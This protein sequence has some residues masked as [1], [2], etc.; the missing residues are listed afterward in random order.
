MATKFYFVNGHAGYDPPAFQGAWDVEATTAT[1]CLDPVK[2]AQAIG[3]PGHQEV[4][5]AETLTTNPTRVCV[6]RMISRRLAAQTI[7]GTVDLCASVRESSGNLNAFTR[8]HLYVQRVDDDSILG[9]LINQYEESSGGGGTEWPTG[10]TGRSLQSAQT[11]SDVTIPNDGN[12]YRLV[13]ELGVRAENTSATSM[14]GLVFVGARSSAN[15]ESSTDLVAGDAAL[16]SSRPGWIEF[17]GTVTL[18][19]DS[20]T[21]IRWEDAT[22]LGSNVDQT[23]AFDLRQGGA[24]YTRWWKYT[25][26]ADKVVSFF[27]WYDEGGGTLRPKGIIYNPDFSNMITPAGG[28]AASNATFTGVPVYSSVLSGETLYFAVQPNSFTDGPAAGDLTFES[29]AYGG[30]PTSGVYGMIPSDRGGPAAIID[31]GTGEVTVFGK[32]VST[33]GGDRLGNKLMLADP[34]DTGGFVIYDTDDMSVV[35]TNTTFFP[36]TNT[37]RTQHALNTFTVVAGTEMKQFSDVGA[38]VSTHTV[39]SFISTHA[40]DNAGAFLYHTTGVTNAPIKKWNLQTETAETD[41][42]AGI[43][44][45]VVYDLFVLSDGSILALYFQSSGTPRAIQVKRY[46]TGG[47]VLNTYSI[48]SQSGNP[49]AVTPRMFW[50]PAD[51]SNFWVWWH[52]S[53]GVT[54]FTKLDIATGSV[55]ASFDTPDFE[56]SSQTGGAYDGTPAADAPMWGATNSCPMVMF[57][58][59]P[60]LPVIDD[61]DPCCIDLSTLAQALGG[62][63]GGP[64]AGPGA[65]GPME[66][67]RTGTWSSSLNATG[68]GS[69]G[70]SGSSW[71][72]SD[73]TAEAW[74]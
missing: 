23:F 34:F 61:S 47:S 19:A 60:Q 74:G 72:S 37:I 64:I 56:G 53:S 24:N 29:K 17:S 68:G 43:A 35:T 7:S 46:D 15:Q 10:S 38:E 25:A 49:L 55:V 4:S 59:A 13:M 12:D 11:M 28:G 63:D 27:P 26:P 21:N 30:V 42:A 58:G 52:P 71:S 70:G 14:S 8:L 3:S 22:D 40:V 16:G 62:C 36:G 57:G 69:G 44:S 66:Q 41:L 39:P 5:R 18:H 67:P 48:G 33:E 51:A 6:V 32:T 54:R 73:P 1:R 20:L 31:T 65:T 50:N 45:H 2:W 9:T